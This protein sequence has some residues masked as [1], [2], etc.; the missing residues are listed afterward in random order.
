MNSPMPAV[1]ADQSLTSA[2]GSNGSERKY[3]TNTVQIEQIT[4]NRET[5]TVKSI[6]AL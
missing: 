6:V 3:Q 2:S 4:R 1:A 5:L